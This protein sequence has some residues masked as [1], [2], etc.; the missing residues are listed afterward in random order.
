MNFVF[1]HSFF[2]CLSLDGTKCNTFF[3]FTETPSG[4]SIKWS[5]STFSNFLEQ[6]LIIKWVDDSINM[7]CYLFGGET[8]APKENPQKLSKSTHLSIWADIKY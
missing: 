8:R 4:I 3:R 7:K 6:C 5:V 2:Y 1:I